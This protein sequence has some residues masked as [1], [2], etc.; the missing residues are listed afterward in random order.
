MY[1]NSMV[2]SSISNRLN[3]F[4]SI[5]MSNLDSEQNN[6]N[7]IL[8]NKPHDPGTNQMSSIAISD[9]KPLPTIPSNKI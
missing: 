9:V 6:Q 1:E 2:I 3:V 8:L 7:H 5:V 4:R